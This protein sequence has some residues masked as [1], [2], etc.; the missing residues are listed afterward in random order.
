MPVKHLSGK[1]KQTDVNLCIWY[2]YRGRERGSIIYE[3][4]VN[5]VL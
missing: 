3:Q 4:K 2:K 1:V 5:G